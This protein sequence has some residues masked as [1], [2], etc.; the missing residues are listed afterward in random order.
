MKSLVKALMVVI[1]TR[2]VNNYYAL[3]QEETQV[4]TE[5]SG[6]FAMCFPQKRI[7]RCAPHAIKVC[8]ILEKMLMRKNAHLLLDRDAADEDDTFSSEI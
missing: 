8:L 7:L 3:N 1:A 5:Q 4:T 2:P 6:R